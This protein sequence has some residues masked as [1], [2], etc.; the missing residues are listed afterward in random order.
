MFFIDT[1]LDGNDAWDRTLTDSL[2]AG[3]E[4]YRLAQ[5]TVLGMGGV[6]ILKAL[7]FHALGLPASS[8]SSVPLARYHMNEGHAALLT[9]ALVAERTGGKIPTDLSPADHAWVQEHCVFT[10][11]TPVPAGHDRFPVSLVAETLGQEACK[12]L[13][14]WHT[15]EAGSLNMTLL[16]MNFARYIN[17]VAKRHGEVSRDMFKGSVQTKSR[18]IVAI[19]NGVHGESWIG[20]PMQALFDE[21]IPEWRRDNAYLRYMRDVAPE[22]I[23]VAHREAKSQ[24]IAQVKERTGVVLDPKTFTIGFARRAAEYKRADLLFSDLKRLEAV[25]RT[26]GPIQV[27]FA[28]KAHPKDL[29]GKKLIANVSAAA[30]QLDGNLVKVVYV[31]NYDMQLGLILTSGVDL[32]LNTPLKPLEASGTS[33]MKAAMNGVPSFSTLDGWWV[34]GCFEGV[35]GWEIDDDQVADPAERPSSVSAVAS[36]S[37][38]G[39][40]EKTILPLYYKNK[41]GWADVMRGS[42]SINGSFFSTHRMVQQYLWFAYR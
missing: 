30:G 25:A 11:H 7:G 28:G 17:G 27:V 9:L 34:E 33:G 2:Y 10:T 35:T 5:E 37:I 4:R 15:V 23:V 31:P 22:R 3:D 41:A 39:K 29:G 42:I 20:K 38:Y 19:T 12:A 1:N 16:A 8:S 13:E 18:K 32:W 36:A 40:L 14:K 24:M 6:V 21:E 26:S